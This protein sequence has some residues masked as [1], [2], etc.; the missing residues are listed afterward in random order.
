MKKKNFFRKILKTNVFLKFCRAAT[1]IFCA[2]VIHFS[3]HIQSLYPPVSNPFL[4]RIPNESTS[5]SG[6]FDFLTSQHCWWAKFQKTVNIK[7]VLKDLG[8]VLL[9]DNFSWNLTV[10]KLYAIYWK[11]PPGIY[12]KLSVC[13]IRSAYVV[14][15]CISHEPS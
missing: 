4:R 1:L 3:T 8:N 5:Y 11:H 9:V 13:T 12:A 14:K 15:S 6:L 7:N 10:R 2:Y